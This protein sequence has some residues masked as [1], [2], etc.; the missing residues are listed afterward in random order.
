MVHHW[1]TEIR[2]LYADL[3]SPSWPGLARPSPE[4]SAM[5]AARLIVP[6]SGDGRGRPGQ[7]KGHRSVVRPA[8]ITGL[9]ADDFVSKEIN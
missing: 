1:N 2:T 8:G 6:V 3:L 5:S 9:N 7:D 4:G